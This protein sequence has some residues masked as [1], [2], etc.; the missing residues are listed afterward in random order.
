MSDGSSRAPLLDSLGGRGGQ[1]VPLLWQL[2][3]SFFHTRSYTLT[4]A[5]TSPSMDSSHQGLPRGVLMSCWFKVCNEIL[6]LEVGQLQGQGPPGFKGL[7][8]T[9]SLEPQ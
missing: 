7:S 6:G 1:N 8:L 4:Q 3:H 5:L 2:G 9:Q